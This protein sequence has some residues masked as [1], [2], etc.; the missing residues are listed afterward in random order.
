MEFFN[1]HL[2]LTDSFF[3]VVEMVSF[4]AQKQDVESANMKEKNRN[5][6]IV[7]QYFNSSVIVKINHTRFLL[8]YSI[9]IFC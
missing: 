8:I 7:N 4:D 3:M 2:L 6:R 9:L 5:I 1:R